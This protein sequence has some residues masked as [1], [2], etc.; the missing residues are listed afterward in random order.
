MSE[1]DPDRYL[2]KARA[3][4]LVQCARLDTD[5]NV[6]AC[7][8]VYRLAGGEKRLAWYEDDHTFTSIE[9]MRDRLR[10]LEKYLKL[11]PMEPEIVK[12]LQ[13]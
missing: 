4:M 9:A 8:E 11:R 12:F 3:P 5:D 7:P 10:W 6:R 2:P 13:H 1:A